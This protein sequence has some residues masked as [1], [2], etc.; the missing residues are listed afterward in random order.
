MI[1]L[2]R[3]MERLIRELAKLPSIGE[4]TA[5]RLAYSLLAENRPLMGQLASALVTAQ[6]AVR[7]CD[8]CFFITESN[9]CELCHDTTRDESQICVVEKPM[10]IIALERAKLFSGRYHVLHGVWAPLRGRGPDSIKLKELVDRVKLGVIKEVVL[11]M[12][13]TV[14]G[15]ATGLYI[16]E[17]LKDLPVK[18]TRIAQGMPKGGE[19]E[20]ADEVT[21]SRAFAGR[22]QMS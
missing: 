21:L 15:D 18:V 4:R 7:L 3:S 8:T 20:F 19:L 13:S 2:P 22:Q 9:H 1:Q 16:A 17:L 11:A 14:E 5:L 6:Q 12:S 10:D